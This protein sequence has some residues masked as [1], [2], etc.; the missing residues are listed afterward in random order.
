MI[1]LRAAWSV[2]PLTEVADVRLGRQRSPKNHSGDH[3]RPYLRAANVTWHGLDLSDVKSMNFT[4]VEM[5]TYRLEP[6]DILLS[7]ASGS[8]SEVGKAALWT[9]EIADCAFQNTLIRLRPR[10]VDPRYLLHYF[11]WQALAGRFIEQSRGVG[12][13][14]IGRAR[15]ASWPTPVPLAAEQ[16]RIVDILEDLLSRLDAAD[17]YL[18]ASVGRHRSL[19]ASV[20]TATIPDLAE[21]PAHWQSVTVADAGH[22]ELGRQRHPDWH[23]GP[24]MHPYLRVANVFEDRIDAS[25]LKEMHWSGGTF[26]RFRLNPGEVL[27]NEGQSPEWLGR[28]AIYRG[29]PPDVAFTNSLL[30][31]VANRDVL[32]EFAL[33]VFRRHMHAGRFR[34]ESRITTNIAHLSASRLKSVEFPIPP[35]PEQERLVEDVTIRLDAVAT[36]IDQVRIGQ[37]RAR[38]LRRA[39]LA[40]AFSG[41]LTGRASDWD[42]AEELVTSEAR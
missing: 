2:L 20:L 24:N 35:L 11:R 36:V 14:H 31:F 10:S 21:Y 15:L 26:E 7:E 8:A 27:L 22:L 23:H 1:A 40:A 18:N 38:S 34:R 28:P 29:A 5:S 30:R 6:G 13:H 4:D 33:L 37:A 19:V 25:D 16:R 39:V 9:G 41:R 17:A 42:L 32:P 3:M 12:I